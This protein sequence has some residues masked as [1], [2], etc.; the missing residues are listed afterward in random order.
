MCVCVRWSQL[1]ENYYI[2]S[3]CYTNMNGLVP[4]RLLP[5][6]NDIRLNFVKLHTK[7]THHHQYLDGVSLI[8]S[9]T[10][11]MVSKFGAWT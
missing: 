9:D 8:L 1:G 6:Y 7:Q 2:I 4:D 3:T 11:Y 5:C 10:N